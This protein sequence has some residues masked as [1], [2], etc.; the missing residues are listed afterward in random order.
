MGSRMAG[1]IAGAEAAELAAVCSRTP[2]RAAE[3]AVAFGARG[4]SEYEALLADPGV[5][6]V[7]VATETHLH[8]ARAVEALRAGKHVLVEK[9]L[10]LSVEDARAVARAAEETGLRAG[11][12]F[13]LRVHP[14]H[15][16]LRDLL[17][18]EWVGPAVLAQALWGYYSA[19]WSPES[20]KM[21]P[22]RAGAGSLAGLGVH[23]IDLLRFVLGSEPVEVVAVSDGPGDERPVEFTTAATLVFASG[24]LAQ[25][26]S[27]RRLRNTEDSLR[28]YADEARLDA[29]GTLTTEPAGRLEL[30]RAGETE[31]RDLPLRDLYELEIEACSAA[32]EAGRE[33]PATALDGVRSVE[34]LAAVLESARTGAAVALAAPA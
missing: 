14:V 28:V 8:A 6:A 30:T 33:L 31:V 10:A 7:Y 2:E 1:A 26:V 32:I 3:V 29:V 20:W 17:G 5:D 13:H 9:P 24:A 19:H 22:R 18:S 12:G 23:L 4:H 34:I 11:V 16:A 21:D 15:V 27:S 25:L